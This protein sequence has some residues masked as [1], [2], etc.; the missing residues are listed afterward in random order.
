MK[1][2]RP[3]DSNPLTYAPLVIFLIIVAALI[4]AASSC[5]TTV[6]AGHVGVVK[7]F[8]AVQE[9][10]L[11]EGLHFKIPFVEEVELM[12]TR[13]ISSTQSAESASRDL[14]NVAT[15]V[16][17]QFFI[18]GDAAP[19]ILQKVGNLSKV[20]FTLIEPATQESVKAVTAKFTA[21]ELVTKRESVKLEIQAA[22][23]NFLRVSLAEKDLG[24]VIR[25]GNVAITQFRFSSEFERAIELKVK[26]EQEAL[27]ARNEKI[28][29][30]T[31]AEASAAEKKLAAEAMATQIELESIARAEAIRREAEALKGN[32]ELIT[33]RSIE[34]WDGV[35]PRMTGAGNAVPFLN[36]SDTL[37]EQPRPRAVSP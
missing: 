17:V 36:L 8:G 2:L 25:I 21:E 22:L 11:P 14:Q 4:S 34:R 13:L 3:S 6:D 26:A 27:Q 35:L 23:V 10:S 16:A 12:D 7:R 37:G 1:T 5:F 29:R 18:L 33:L 20:A 31:Q 32:P 28:R 19:Q 24:E 9:R 30:V 15:E